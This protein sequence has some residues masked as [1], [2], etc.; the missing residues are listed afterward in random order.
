M[1]YI[2]GSMAI[3]IAV[4]TCATAFISGIGTCVHIGAKDIDR[5]WKMAYLC[6]GTTIVSG[7]LIGVAVML[8]RNVS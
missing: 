1:E 7:F 5:A 4:L 2:I 6:V 8:L 3:A